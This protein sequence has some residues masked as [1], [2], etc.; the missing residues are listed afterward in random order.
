MSDR[1]KISPVSHSKQ[2][3][4]L[5]VLGNLTHKPLEGQLADEELRRLLVLANLAQRDG[6]GAV[7]VGLLHATCHARGMLSHKFPKSQS[8]EYTHR[9]SRVHQ[10]N[11]KANSPV[12]GAD[13]RAAL[14]AS[15][16]RGA[17]PPVDLR[18]VCLVRA[19]AAWFQV[20]AGA[21]VS[22]TGMR[23]VDSKTLSAKN[24]YLFCL[25]SGF[26]QTAKPQRR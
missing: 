23:F 24:I 2:H 3:T 20:M 10:R 7:P 14:V 4:S 21:R 5:E 16:L 8:S 6:A 11:H 17:L 13:L 15:C 18:A 26:P 22:T 12:A 25:P 19:I 9:S 1:L